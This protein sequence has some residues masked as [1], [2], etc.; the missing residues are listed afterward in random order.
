M[1][2]WRWVWRRIWRKVRGAVSWI[3]QMVKVI[4][5]CVIIYRSILIRTWIVKSW[6]L[7]TFI[8]ILIFPITFIHLIVVGTKIIGN[9]IIWCKIDF[10]LRLR[11]NF[12]SWPSLLLLLLS[13]W[14]LLEINHIVF[15][16]IWIHTVTILNPRFLIFYCYIHIAL[17]L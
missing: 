4:T 2:I 8:N 11:F 16:K 6:S 3:L 12:Y 1:R 7:K 15:S 17:H 10:L 5:I 9:T 14:R 13:I